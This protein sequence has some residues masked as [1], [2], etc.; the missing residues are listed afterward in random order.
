MNCPYCGA[1]FAPGTIIARTSVC[2]QCGKDLHTC[3]SCRFYHPG[4][5]YDCSEDIDEPV[6]EKDLPNFCG[7]F[8]LKDGKA[9]T[10]DEQQRK[11]EEA[12]AKA[13][14]LFDF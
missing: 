1:G 5:H 2:P 4:L 14:A 11:K 8:M 7:S 9:L 3:I 10:K 6:V 12:L 13:N